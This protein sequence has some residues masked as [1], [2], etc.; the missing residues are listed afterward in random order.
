MPGNPSKKAKYISAKDRVTFYPKGTLHEN[1]GL[2]FC[3]AC[4]VSIDYVQKSTIDNHLK[5]ATHLGKKEKLVTQSRPVLQSSIESGFKKTTESKAARN[6]L[7][8]DLVHA[9]GSADI[10]LEKLDNL[11][12]RTFLNTHV[13]NGGSIPTASRL[14]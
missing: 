9:F 3:S 12:L 5:C 11:A 14:R 1:G 10:P 7:V 6:A 13:V 2:L 8:L 4:N